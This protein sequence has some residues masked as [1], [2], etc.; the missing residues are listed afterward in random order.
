MRRRPKLH[1][2][3]AQHPE[4]AQRRPAAFLDRDGVLNHDD[5]FIA[6]PARVRWIDGAARA[7]RRLNAAGYFV[8]IVTNQSGVAR[9]LFSEAQVEAVNAF[10]RASLAA[11]GARIDD[12]R[13]CPHHPDGTHDAYR[14][15]CDWRKPG[16]GMLL[17]LMRSWPV[18]S[19][20]SFM[21]GDRDTDLQA[22]QGAG[23]RGF[24]FCGG[25]LEAFVENCLAATA[26]KV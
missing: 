9:G 13:F 8:F 17:D 3:A 4:N 12:V 1:A 25:D 19:A 18:E 2:P 22:A 15:V 26:A 10:I 6:D 24:L 7:V 21:I 16:A 11:D 14:E 23:I 20:G 5:G